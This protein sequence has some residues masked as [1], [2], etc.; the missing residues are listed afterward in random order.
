MEN[1]IKLAIDV[2]IAGLDEEAKL[3]TKE[4]NKIFMKLLI[5][6]WNSTK[7]TMKLVGD[8]LNDWIVMHSNI[9]KYMKK[10]ANT[11]SKKSAIK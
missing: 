1:L 8:A 2:L 11:L 6:E 3:Q 10:V 7:E 4:K 9:L 5:Q